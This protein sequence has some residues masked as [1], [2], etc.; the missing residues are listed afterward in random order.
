MFLFTLHL[1]CALILGL[2]F[3]SIYCQLFYRLLPKLP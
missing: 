2:G 3:C 1:L